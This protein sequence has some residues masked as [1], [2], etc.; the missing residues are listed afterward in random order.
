[1]ISSSIPLQRVIAILLLALGI[2]FASG[3]D[4][5]QQAVEPEAPTTRPGPSGAFDLDWELFDAVRVETAGDRKVDVVLPAELQ[6]EIEI[7]SLEIPENLRKLTGR[8][9]RISGVGYLTRSGVIDDAV[10]QFALLPPSAISCA[11]CALP[12]TRLSWTIFVD[13]S[14]RAW[15]LP[16][17][18]PFFATVEGVLQIEKDNYLGCLFVLESARATVQPLEE[19][20]PASH[21]S[22][23][24]PENN[25]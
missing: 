7:V 20:I 6:Q 4:T 22:H 1:M 10:H 21:D 12:D 18:D 17:G 24:K 23:S 14:R 8:A 16:D 11:C 15:P 13:C 19:P 25:E 5:G 2:L 3:C 9:V